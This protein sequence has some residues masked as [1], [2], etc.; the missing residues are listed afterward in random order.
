MKRMLFVALCLG[1][2]VL[3]VSPSAR[4]DSLNWAGG[5]DTTY[6]LCCGRDL[7][8]VPFCRN[9]RR[10]ECDTYGGRSVLDCAQCREAPEYTTG[11]GGGETS[12]PLPE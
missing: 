1:S 3:L 12:V 2:L 10:A 5:Y 8:N 6:V 4:P 7:G 11:T 9:M